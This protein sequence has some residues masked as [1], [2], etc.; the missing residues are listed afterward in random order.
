MESA[1]VSRDTERA[2]SE[3]QVEVVHGLVEAW[4][5][6]D[7]DAFVAFFGPDCEVVFRPDVPEPGPFRGHAELRAWVEGFL[8]AWE[9]H[10]AEVLEIRATDSGAFASV[11]FVGRGSG[12]NIE[13]DETDAHLFAFKER[14]VVRWRNFQAGE[15]ALA[16][17]GLSE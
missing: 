9:F 10:R 6:A 8:A 16:A 11:H 12:S 13:M 4:N 2:M 14:R 7:V 1:T 5:R 15:E 17:A 3:E